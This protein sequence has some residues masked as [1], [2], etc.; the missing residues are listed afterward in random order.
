MA[1]SLGKKIIQGLTEL[2]QDLVAGVEIK[3]KYVV[4][5]YDIGGKNGFDAKSVKKTGLAL[6]IGP[7][8]FAEILGVTRQTVLAWEAAHRTPTRMARRFP[9]RNSTAN[10][11]FS[12]PASSP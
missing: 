3:K 1:S 6:G 4:H 9:G 10:R 11:L 12:H 7:G 2:K 8:R 5:Q